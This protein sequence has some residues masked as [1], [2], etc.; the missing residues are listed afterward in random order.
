MAIQKI[1][2][3]SEQ[4]EME[5]QIRIHKIVER[6]GVENMSCLWKLLKMKKDEEANLDL[7]Q[8]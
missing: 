2:N 1:P 7:K 4:L 6:L 5:Y 8:V 3:Y